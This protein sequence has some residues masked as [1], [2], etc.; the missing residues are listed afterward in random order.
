MKYR[1]K[2]SGSTSWISRSVGALLGS[3]EGG[4]EE[5]E[6]YARISCS[7]GLIPAW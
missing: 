3:G 6:W 7:K 4:M 2:N 5:G 1:D